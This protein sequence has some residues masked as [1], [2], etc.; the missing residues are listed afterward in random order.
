PREGEEV[1]ALLALAE[2]ERDR[3][4]GQRAAHKGPGPAGQRQH[5]ALAKLD[6]DLAVEY[7]D[8]RIDRGDLDAL[9][10]RRG[11]AK[12]VG[13]NDCARSALYRSEGGGEVERLAGEPAAAGYPLL[14]PIDPARPGDGPFDI[15]DHAQHQLAERLGLELPVEQ[16]PGYRE[17]GMTPPGGE[18][19]ADV[20]IGDHAV[21][22]RLAQRRLGQDHVVLERQRAA[23][24]DKR[25]EA[26]LGLAVDQAELA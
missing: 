6:P 16:Q 9:V 19:V 20:H 18:I 15:G 7:L 5:P 8:A 12:K 11:E 2:V 24:R 23:T 22:C 25:L 26:R 17:V 3:T 4:Q 21:G 10:G 14:V 13:E 1:R